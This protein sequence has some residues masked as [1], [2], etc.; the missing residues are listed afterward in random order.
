MRPAE[1]R[2]AVRHKRR[3]T[4]A[5]NRRSRRI[6]CFQTRDIDLEGAFI[7]AAPPRLHLNDIVELVFLTRDGEASDYTLLAG[8]VR[9]TPE[10]V[11]VMLLDFEDKALGVLRDTTLMPVSG[12]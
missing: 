3:L 12:G 6:G 5:V 2:Y 9:L 10:G 8:V 7:E 11:G 4:V 1:L